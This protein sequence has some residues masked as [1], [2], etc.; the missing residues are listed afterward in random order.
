[1]KKLLANKKPKPLDIC[2][3]P[4]SAGIL[5]IHFAATPSLN[6]LVANPFASTL[7]S[8]SHEN[9]DTNT[10]N[11]DLY[12]KYKTLAKGQL[13]RIDHFL[14]PKINVLVWLTVFM[15]KPKVIMFIL[16]EEM[17]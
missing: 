17:A 5:G 12:K 6:P 1:M 13:V 16:V 11:F 14:M 15:I 10:L 3:I 4:A 9:F 2:D 8:F 7:A